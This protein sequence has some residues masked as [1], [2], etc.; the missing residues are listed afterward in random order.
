M[1]YAQ[2]LQEDYVNKKRVPAPIYQID[3]YLFVDAR[4]LRLDRPSRKLDFRSYG[5]YPIVKIIS[6]RLSQMLTPFSKSTIFA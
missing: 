4:N 6:F 1:N 5:P 2:A 3:D